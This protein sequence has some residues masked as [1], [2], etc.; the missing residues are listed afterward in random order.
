MRPPT[1]LL[2]DDEPNLLLGLAAIMQRAGYLVYK[3]GNGSEGLRLAQEQLPDI[4]VSDVMMPP[5]NGLELRK[6]LSQ[7]S[8]TAQ[9]PF[10]FLT[11]RLA[12]GDR[13]AGLEVGADD[14]ITKP[15]NREEL[16]ARVAAVLRRQEIG[17]QQGRRETLA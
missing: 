1:I 14:Y 7:D 8:T 10:I 5:P 12:Q 15:F 6:R 11:A 9:I 13:L 4:I 3:A 16:V 17:R 2:I